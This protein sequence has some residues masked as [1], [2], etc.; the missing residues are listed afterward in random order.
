MNGIDLIPVARR[1]AR[2]KRARLRGW[3]FA[4]GGYTAVVAGGLL[5]LNV[6][7]GDAPTL[8]RHEVAAVEGRIAEQT[9]QLTALKAKL[10]E[11]ESHL[12]LLREVG[13][14]PDWGM[15]LAVVAGVRG[16]TV[17]VQ[18]MVLEEA[19]PPAPDRRAAGSTPAAEGE[20]KATGN[21]RTYVLH[22]SGLGQTQAEAAGFVLRLERTG[23][24][25]RVSLVGS[26]RQVHQGMDLVGFTVRCEL[27][28]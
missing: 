20:S 6:L 28:G 5:L 25:E 12:R 2:A 24:F 8:L 19:P 16:E 13:E 17:A 14:Q 18:S 23:L 26:G 27:K 7:P 11:A 9:Q 10:L 3:G 15:L 4:A 1:E 22:V 21:G